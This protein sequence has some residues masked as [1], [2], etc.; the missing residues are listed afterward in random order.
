MNKKKSQK[1]HYS[2]L[3]FALNSIIYSIITYLGNPPR[4]CGA[5][6]ARNP[7]ENKASNDVT[8]FF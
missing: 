1:L 2:E 8:N 4:N 7:T 5:I 3:T 6:S